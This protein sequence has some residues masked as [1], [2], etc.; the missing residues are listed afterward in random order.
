MCS[1]SIL[2]LIL[3][4]KVDAR[5]LSCLLQQLGI[6]AELESK[7]LLPFLD[8]TT[9]RCVFTTCLAV[10]GT[11]ARQ[12]AW[13]VYDCVTALNVPLSSATYGAFYHAVNAVKIRDPGTASDELDAY[14][15]LEEM[16][17]TWFYQR[18][19]IDSSAI[20]GSGANSR[21]HTNTPSS[22]NTRASSI[23]SPQTTRQ[24]QT[25]S[26]SSG[27]FSFFSRSKA[28]V[29]SP[30]LVRRTEA[31]S[32]TTRSFRLQKAY[33]GAASF[34]QPI[35]FIPFPTPLHRSV[36]ASYATGVSAYYSALCIQLQMRM[37]KLHDNALTLNTS[38][39]NTPNSD[40]NN[41]AI[42]TPIVLKSSSIALAREEEPVSALSKDRSNPSTPAHVHPKT[43]TDDYS[44]NDSD[45]NSN[46]SV[47]SGDGGSLNDGTRS[48]NTDFIPDHF[49]SDDEQV[50][51]IGRNSADSSKQITRT[52]SS[53]IKARTPAASHHSPV[54]SKAIQNQASAD[55][56]LPGRVSF[57]PESALKV[58]IPTLSK[59]AITVHKA[60]QQLI[61]PSDGDQ[62]LSLQSQ[63][64][65]IMRNNI[66]TVIGIHT[67]TQCKCGYSLLDD[68]LLV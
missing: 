48:S 7:S 52:I 66:S 24:P 17:L 12:I 6:L 63:I 2:L 18:S 15:Y 45:H 10:G 41:P 58:G 5:P 9:W 14:L 34:H 65:D 50:K 39:F 57:G 68:E 16:G 53:P 29:D 31:V 35:E 32:S 64:L 37:S 11:F 46:P 33:S 26:S 55:A 38:L 27:V 51:A 23:A 61:S 47:D 22:P 25:S 62:V 13:T 60:Q 56:A 40:R 21:A 4:A 3:R 19:A 54:R 44:D 42:H 43:L 30:S 49:D 8:E 67:H 59:P 1:T 20:H 28:S 36:T